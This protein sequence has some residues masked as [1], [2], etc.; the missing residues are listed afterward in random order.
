MT[1]PKPHG[2]VLLGY[3]LEDPPA[4]EVLDSAPFSTKKDARHHRN[5]VRRIFLAEPRNQLRTEVQFVIV[6]IGEVIK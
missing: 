5:R 3:G 6:P 2:Y 4:W 1:A